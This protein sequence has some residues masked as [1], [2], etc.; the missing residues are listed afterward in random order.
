MKPQILYLITLISSFTFYGQVETCDSPVEDLISDLNSITKCSL[1]K[2][3][4]TSNNKSK[5]VSVVVSS[6]RRVIRKKNIATG[7]NNTN[8][9]HKIK[10]LPSNL[11]TSDHKLDNLKH[12]KVI[13]FD[14]VE[15]T[16]LFNKCEKSPILKQRE[17]FK[18]ELSSHIA[19]NFK[20]PEEAYDNAVQGRTIVYFMINSD[21]SVGKIKVSSPYKGNALASEAERIIKK[22]PNFKPAKHD[23]SNVAIRYAV[24]IHFKIPGVKASNVREKS[25]NITVTNALT[26]DQVETIPLFEKCS[27]NG[28]TSSNC[29]NKEL[30]NHIENNFAYPQLAA[31]QNIE[32]IIN[33]KFIINTKG[34]VINIQTQGPSNGKI[35]E[36]SARL[37]IQ[38]LP[39]FKPAM[40]N[41]KAV[42]SSYSFPVNFT[43]N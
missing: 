3:E 19:K 12:I 33:V 40:K 37:L 42:N 41:G 38:K 7:L 16:P 23:G 27:T 32:G 14:L 31:E 18:T 8:Y 43:L 35:L 26:F 20:Y 22:L 34:N 24:P 28:D 5:N 15:E 4:G 11:N 2:T 13:P 29:Y 39:K 1:E 36:A 6:R 30:V 17:C 25:N 21:G 10:E 9:D